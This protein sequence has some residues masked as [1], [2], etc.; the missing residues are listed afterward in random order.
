MPTV[1]EGDEDEDEDEEDD[2][3]ASGNAGAAVNNTDYVSYTVLAMNRK[4]AELARTQLIHVQIAVLRFIVNVCSHSQQSGAVAVNKVAKT[5]ISLNC[6]KRVFESLFKAK[7]V[8]EN[9]VIIGLEYLRNSSGKTGGGG[10]LTPDLE[11]LLF[12]SGGDLTTFISEVSQ[13]YDDE[14]VNRSAVLPKHV[15]LNACLR[16]YQLLKSRGGGALSS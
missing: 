11:S 16:E 5:L 4:Y 9:E 2:R 3:D 15:F 14:G 6:T 8:F 13:N 12:N 1:A 10:I 7:A